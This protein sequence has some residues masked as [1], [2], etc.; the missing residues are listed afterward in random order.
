MEVILFLKLLTAV[1][2][3]GI[4]GFEREKVHRPAGLKTNI[5]ICLGST[6]ITHIA[7]T[8]TENMVILVAAIISGIGFLGAGTIINTPNRVLGLTTA[9]SLWVVAALGVALGLGLFQEAFFAVV[10]AYLVLVVGHFLEVKLNLG[11]E[12]KQ[13]KTK[14]F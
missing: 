9:A 13:R 4:I 5:L 11:K 3:G 6:L 12:T 8:Y 14:P 1:I 10:L 7:I 2:V